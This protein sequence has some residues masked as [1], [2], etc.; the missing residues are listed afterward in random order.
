MLACCLLHKLMLNINSKLGITAMETL[1]KLVEVFFLSPKPILMVAVIVFFAILSVV[2]YRDLYF[3]AGD[4]I[5]NTTLSICLIY[6]VYC[7]MNLDGPATIGPSV[8]FV[9]VSV[10]WSTII[11]IVFNFLSI[12][13][14]RRTA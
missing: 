2:R 5:Q 3:A 10:F 8:V 7:L 14:L 9:I 4:L 6:T 1:T 12:K 11:K 13:H